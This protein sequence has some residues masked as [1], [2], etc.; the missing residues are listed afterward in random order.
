[1]PDLGRLALPGALGH[2]L[3]RFLTYKGLNM[4]AIIKDRH[5]H[6]L[7]RLILEPDAPLEPDVYARIYADNYGFEPLGD[8]P[9]HVIPDGC[10]DFSVTIQE[11]PGSVICW[12]S[13]NYLIG[14][15]A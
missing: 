6:E 2:A 3:C 13:A 10:E 8:C 4:Y 15:E 5:G 12:K 1:V 9:W 7:N 11:E 14:E